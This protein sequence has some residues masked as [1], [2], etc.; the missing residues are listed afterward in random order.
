MRLEGIFLLLISLLGFTELDAAV[1]SGKITDENGQPVP[2]ASVYIHELST[3]VSTDEKGAFRIT[4]QQGI[5]TCE[6]SSL[7]Y[8]RERFTI[9]IDSQYVTKTIILKEEIY[10]LSDVTFRGGKEDRAMS[11]MRRAIA[12]A[13]YHRQQVR[14][15]E[16]TLYMKG[17]MK[18][19]IASGA[20][21]SCWKEI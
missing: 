17:S 14:G 10:R 9:E 18:A 15:Y 4:L 21:I 12:K 3:G 6:V 8:K 1:F 7:G 13:P 19:C 16:S 2:Y 11:V 20:K 5:Y